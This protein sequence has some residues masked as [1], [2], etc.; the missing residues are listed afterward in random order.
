MGP[1]LRAVILPNL[2]LQLSGAWQ[3]PDNLKIII[4]VAEAGELRV[5]VR[6]SITPTSNPNQAE[7]RR[8]TG[9]SC[10]SVAI[11]FSIR[12]VKTDITR[13]IG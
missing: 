7:S 2:L 3:I 6:A 1:A 10:D 13:L 8:A 12:F 11:G 4:V 5:R 9:V